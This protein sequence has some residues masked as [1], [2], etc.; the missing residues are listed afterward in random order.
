MAEE[1]ISSPSDANILA[2]TIGHRVLLNVVW[3]FDPAKDGDLYDFARCRVRERLANYVGS[4]APALMKEHHQPF[5]TVTLGV[6]AY[7]R[8]AQSRTHPEG[9]DDSQRAARFIAWAK[10]A[11]LPGETREELL[12]SATIRFTPWVKALAGSHEY[13]FPEMPERRAELIQA[14]AVRLSNLLRRFD[15]EEHG[16]SFEEFAHAEIVDKLAEKYQ[17]VQ[18]DIE[19]RVRT[20]SR[21]QSSQSPGGQRTPATSPNDEASEARDLQYDEASPSSFPTETVI[22]TEHSPT[23]NDRQVVAE[24]RLPSL[25]P[26]PDKLPISDPRV[27]ESQ[28]TSA[29]VFHSPDSNSVVATGSLGNGQLGL[30]EEAPLSPTED[31][32]PS[33]PETLDSLA[34]GRADETSSGTEP[35]VP[36]DPETERMERFSVWA[37][38]LLGQET[39]A[40]NHD[41]L[42][43]KICEKY[44]PITRSHTIKV[45]KGVER[46]NRGQQITVSRDHLI[47][48][49]RTALRQAATHYDPQADGDFVAHAKERMEQ[50]IRAEL[51]P[52][53]MHV[54]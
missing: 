7:D 18:G 46:V 47:A 3:T 21:R 52:Q 2:R 29:I 12:R 30:T 31:P 36:A 4:E 50:A 14:G 23:G 42:V 39:Q 20:R 9:D 15:P 8:I 35:E 28:A 51:R 13:Q 25:T 32:L 22:S 53:I 27:G 34:E 17:F 45:V 40:Y 44:E 26:I 33:A 48:V 6:W 43:D 49:A 11:G 41:Q 38:G 24:D 1:F 54:A 10:A 5:A 16:R 37:K 19:R